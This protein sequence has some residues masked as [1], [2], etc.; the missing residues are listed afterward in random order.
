MDEAK[1]RAE[2]QQALTRIQQGL[3]TKVHILVDRDSC[4]VCQ[5]F[6]GVYTFEDVPELP[7]EGC[8]RVDGCH[9]MY[10]PVLDKFG[11]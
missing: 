8:S 1:K 2:Q 6:A 9:A 11:P 10:A 7:L 4:P 3:A 5:H